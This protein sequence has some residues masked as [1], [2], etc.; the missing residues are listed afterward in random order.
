MRRWFTTEHLAEIQ[1]QYPHLGR[2]EIVSILQRAQAHNRAS[3]IGHAIMLGAIVVT[4]AL[5]FFR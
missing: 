1:K 3:D 4:L 5:V 2:D